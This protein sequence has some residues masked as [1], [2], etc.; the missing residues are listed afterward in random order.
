MKSYMAYNWNPEKEK[1]NRPKAYAYY[2]HSAEDRQ[3]NSIPIQK[4]QIME[5]ASKNDIEI[6]R[7]FQDA[8]VS[9]LTDKRK[10]F[11][12]LIH[13][14]QSEIDKVEFIFVLDASR[15]GRFQDINQAA[16][17][18]WECTKHNAR[19]VHI[20]R[21][22]LED[23][24]HTL[25][26]S[27]LLSLD[28]TMAAEYSRNLSDKVFRGCRKIAE[29]GYRA[30]GPAPY[31]LKRIL[32]DEQRNYVQDLRPGQHKSINNQR[33]SLAPGPVNEVKVINEIFRSF[34]A[35]G[36][37]CKAIARA[38]NKKAI[39]SPLGKSWTPSTILKRLQ[40]ELYIGTMVYNKT[41]SRLKKPSQKNPYS[42]WVRTPDAFK[43]IIDKE[44]FYLAQKK[45]REQREEERRKYSIEHMS[46]R[47]EELLEKYG[48]I[49]SKIISRSPVTVSV[50]SYKKCFGSLENAY[51][52]LY[53]EVLEK[54]RKQTM[55]SILQA[56]VSVEDYGDFIVID[57]YSSIHIQPRI[58]KSNC[59][60]ANWTITPLRNNNID[61]TLA[62]LL[63]PEGE[64]LGY[65]G[66]FNKIFK[67]EHLK[68]ST[69][70]QKDFD[71]YSFS[72]FEII[73]LLRK[74]QN[75]E[76]I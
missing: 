50:Y 39:P 12:D 74:P 48:C 24:S 60:E 42:E 62:V 37:S 46:F 3:E 14:I 68:L 10:G 55:E 5:F 56:G 35:K 23:T 34:V 47:L 72:L 49:S 15:W 4:E 2:R 58:L 38:L 22:T 1:N 65:L 52:Y 6:V 11:Q 7:E 53:L 61:L 28:R 26:S 54:Y 71:F 36:K 57:N 69:F 16:M 76:N 75:K 44:L 19:L 73:S 30:G 59:F 32:L 17:Y 18:N 43:G 8:G 9:G 41:N 66:I 21:D 13:H 40:N 51:Q 63:T 70:R 64:F 31:G 33:V 45:I 27:I 20:N 25:S 67:N 29:Q